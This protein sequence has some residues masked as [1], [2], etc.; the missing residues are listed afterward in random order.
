M[1]LPIEPVPRGAWGKNLRNVAPAHWPEIRGAVLGAAENRCAVCG[2]GGGPLECDEVWAY[3]DAERVGTLVGLRALCESC[4]GVKH[5]LRSVTLA[6]QG[7][8]SRSD[9][10][11][12]VVHALAVNGCTR[13]EFVAHNRQAQATWKERGRHGWRVSFGE[14]AHHLSARRPPGKAR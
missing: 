4:H 10:E 3:D 14:Y 13:A 1:R 11:A 6:Q 2:A 8:M 5:F 7:R 12:L 9:L